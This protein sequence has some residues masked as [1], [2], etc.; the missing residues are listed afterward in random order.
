MRSDPELKYKLALSL[1][2][3]MN[4]MNADNIIGR[5]GDAETFF[6][7]DARELTT[8]FQCQSRQFG[9]DVRNRAL[10]AAESELGWIESAKSVTPLFFTDEEYPVKLAECEDA[11]VMLY[12][13][14]DYKILSADRIVGMV[15]TRNA[16]GYGE[17]FIDGFVRDLAESDKN[18]LIVSGLAYGVD[19]MSHCA[20]M[21]NGLQTAAVVAHGLSTIYPSA[22]REYARRIVELGGA[23][24]SEYPHDAPIHRANFLARNRIVAGLA[25]GLV[26]VESDVKGG[27]MTT[28]TDADA[29]GRD[30][31]AVPGRFYDRYSSGCNRLISQ[32]KASIVTN[33][34][35]FLQMMNWE[36]PKKSEGKQATL[37]FSLPPERQRIIDYALD[38][39]SR[40]ESYSFNRMAVDLGMTVLELNA[41]TSEMEF[42]G[43]ITRLAGNRI[44]VLPQI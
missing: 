16:T 7:L 40:N 37:E 31:F 11:P 33:A 14:G 5:L 9:A 44:R 10:L 34:G 18:I 38:K 20:A 41:L 8:V 4:K 24:V 13:A 35:E 42:D 32:N 2:K 23:I 27:A 29:Y 19:I 6:R 17:S 39:E 43:L 28:A 26:V 22:H 1:I 12:V 15:G 36:S 3:G 21:D 25:D 30:V